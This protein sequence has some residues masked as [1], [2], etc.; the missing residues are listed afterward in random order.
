MNY[1]QEL[2]ADGVSDVAVY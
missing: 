2:D 1:R